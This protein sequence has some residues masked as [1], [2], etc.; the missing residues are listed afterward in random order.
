MFAPFQ[1]LGFFKFC[2]VDMVNAADVSEVHA[3]SIFRVKYRRCIE[4]LCIDTEV[5][6]SGTGAAQEAGKFMRS[7]EQPNSC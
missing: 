7:V 3:A 2:S 1:I 6:D 5:G 4:F